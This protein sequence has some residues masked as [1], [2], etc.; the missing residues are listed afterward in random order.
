MT[1]SRLPSLLAVAAVL[2]AAACGGSSGS[3]GSG[4]PGATSSKAADSP[5]PA[6]LTSPST[7]A[8]AAKINLQAAD[9]PGFKA[10]PADDSSDDDAEEKKAEEELAKC[11]GATKVDADATYSSDDFSKGE[12]LP[13]LT[14]SSEVD[15]NTD[16]E[17][18]KKDLAG[19]QSDK[20]TSCLQKFVREA[21]ASA[22]EGATLIA[23]TVTRLTP[24]ATGTDATFGFHMATGVAA[25]GQKIPISFDILGL[26]KDRTEVTLLMVGAGTA[27][28]EAQ[29]DAL[30]AKLAAR[31]EANAL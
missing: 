2:T 17:V 1:P 24:P 26:A 6:P 9:L 15:F 28:P 18:V 3:G 8:A 10:T 23:P 31:A 30:F 16:A 19:F 13:S 29:R 11:V 4:G 21:L 27:V 25:G 22:T 14:I 7:A 5:K 20:A 12:S